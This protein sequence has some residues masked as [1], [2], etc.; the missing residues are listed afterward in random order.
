MDTDPLARTVGADPAGPLGDQILVNGTHDPHFTVTSTLT[1][2]RVLNGS[3]ARIYHLGFTDDRPFH[4]VG[5]DTGLLPAPERV[6]RVVVA[7]GERVELVVA[8]RPG[9]RSVLRSFPGGIGT[10][11]PDTRLA[12]ADDT[13]DI[14]QLRAAG[15]LRPAPALP[16]TLS[17]EPRI[18][19]PA[20]A[21][22][23]TLD[24]GG[25]QSINGNLMDLG[26]IDQV[27]TAG[28]REIWEVHGGGPPH[29][30]HIHDVAFR[31]LSIDGAPPPAWL[32]GRKDTVYLPPG[33]TARLAV[34][35]GTDVDEKTPYMYHCHM[36]R[37]EDNGMMGQFVIV[38]PGREDDVATTLDTPHAHR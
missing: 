1:R 4:V 8:M 29:S 10:G 35:F 6:R 37:H 33:T 23:R 13:F 26:R 15:T 34:E 5:T 32:A 25:Q 20:N 38:A 28:A 27:V 7:P 24:L 16:A 17:T 31:I 30:L 22:V 21:R 36:L 18:D 9:E 2:F 3:T 12:G 11:Y 14:L 19:V